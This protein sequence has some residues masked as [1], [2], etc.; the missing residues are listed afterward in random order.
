M[1]IVHTLVAPPLLDSLKELV[2]HLIIID[3]VDE[4]KA[5]VVLIPRLVCLVIDDASDAPYDLAILVG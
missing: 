1:H 3:K 4:T 2:D 5:S